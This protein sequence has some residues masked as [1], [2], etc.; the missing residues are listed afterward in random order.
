MQEISV[1]PAVVTNFLYNNFFFFFCITEM[2]PEY[3]HDP[4]KKTMQFQ[5]DLTQNNHAANYEYPPLN[6]HNG[7]LPIGQNI[8]MKISRSISEH[9]Y[10]VPHLATK[11]DHFYML[12]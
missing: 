10:D 2:Q 5:P 6:P 4:D 9:H 7:H 3:F 8:P 12:I 1:L 11:Y